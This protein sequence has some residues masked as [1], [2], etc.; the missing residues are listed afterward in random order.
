MREHKW[1][2]RRKKKSVK[3][4]RLSALPDEVIY[5]IL[6]FLEMR[7]VVKTCLLSNK[8]KCFW[9]STPALRFDNG[10]F[11]CDF[12]CCDYHHTCSKCKACLMRRDRFKHFV[13]NVLNRRSSNLVKFQLEDQHKVN[14]ALVNE[15][16]NAALERKVQDLD[17]SIDFTKI[18]LLPEMLFS[19]D[20]KVLKLRLKCNAR[21]PNLMCAAAWIKKMDLEHVTLPDGNTNGELVLSFSALESLRVA[22]CDITHLKVIS[23]STPVLESLEMR[24][25]LTGKDRSWKCKIK[26]CTPNLKSLTVLD[27]MWHVDSAVN[28][29]ME[30]LSSIVRALS[31]GGGFLNGQLGSTSDF[32]T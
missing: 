17:I 29:H 28:Y 21:V 14:P 19:S 1:S 5:H 24:K 31:I 7:E 10:G 32:F 11:D 6:S 16:V 8:W 9:M 18:L 3:E 25:F 26:T 2:K 23:I 27:Y 30:N 13:N 4:D 22:R 20:V 12:P 15:W